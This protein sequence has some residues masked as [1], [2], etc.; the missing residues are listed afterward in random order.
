MARAVNDINGIRMATG[1]G[2]V[3]LTDGIVMGVGA[4]GFMI[5]INPYLTLI[6]LLPAP[7]IVY[8]TRIFTRRMFTGYERIQK[9]FSVSYYK[10]AGCRKEST[11]AYTFKSAC[12]SYP[13]LYLVGVEYKPLR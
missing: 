2:M 3:A 1:I 10:G 6:S 12:P 13:Q 4:I 8:M 7:I 9:T 11:S 5:Y